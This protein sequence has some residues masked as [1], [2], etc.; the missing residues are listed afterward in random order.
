MARPTAIE[1]ET[2][3]VHTENNRILNVSIMTN[4]CFIFRWSNGDEVSPRIIKKYCR[5]IN[6]AKTTLEGRI[7]DRQAAHGLNLYRF[8]SNDGTRIGIYSFPSDRSENSDVT[9][10]YPDRMH[11]QKPCKVDR[12]SNLIKP[13][14]VL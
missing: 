4:G 3:L 11:P 7:R 10:T 14:H 5:Q 1:L 8:Q 12:K 2:V 9:Y 13:I 6:N